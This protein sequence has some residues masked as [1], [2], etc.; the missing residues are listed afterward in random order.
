MKR[1]QFHRNLN[2]GCWSYVMSKTIHCRQA[3]LIDVVVRHPSFN[4]KHF[5]KCHAGTGSRKVFAWFKAAKVRP[6]YT[7]DPL[8]LEAIPHNA[9]R[10]H[11]DPTKGDTH[12]HVRRGNDKVI[13]DHLSKV[14]ATADSDGALFAIVETTNGVM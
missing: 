5:A 7:D 11:F 10:I 12:F 8:A 13:V 2:K 9:E 14:W 4:N 3:V 6:E 1:T